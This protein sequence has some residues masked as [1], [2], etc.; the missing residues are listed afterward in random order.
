MPVIESG[1]SGLA[2]PALGANGSLLSLRSSQ[3][4]GMR[5]IFTIANSTMLK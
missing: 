5:G 1:A 3:P 4:S 2:E